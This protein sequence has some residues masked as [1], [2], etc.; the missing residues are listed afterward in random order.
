VSEIKKYKWV[1]FKKNERYTHPFNNAKVLAYDD[2]GQTRVC[3]F[4]G[5]TKRFV[6]EHYKSHGEDC[7]V[8]EDFIDKLI[9]SKFEIEFKHEYKD[10]DNYREI[11]KFINE[12]LQECIMQYVPHFADV[13]AWVY[14]PTIPKLNDDID[15]YDE[16]LIENA[17][18]TTFDVIDAITPALREA[19]KHLLVQQGANK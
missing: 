19:V 5:V 15:N 16:F 4:D 11:D 2:I 17:A 18:F 14:V 10:M 13:V 9:N 3:R 7:Y 8:F 12:Q 1:T 6:I